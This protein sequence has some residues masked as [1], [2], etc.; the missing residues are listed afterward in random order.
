MW[1]EGFVRYLDLPQ[2]LNSLI[3]SIPQGESSPYWT[4]ISSNIGT[5]LTDDGYV[6]YSKGS[7]GKDNIYIGMKNAFYA[8]DQSKGFQ[9]FVYENYIPNVTPGQNSN[10]PVGLNMI[11]ANMNTM[12]ISLG[13]SDSSKYGVFYYLS[14]TR[15]RIIL[16]I[17]FP[18]SIHDRFVD[19]TNNG[20]ALIN[21][22]YMG[23]I[24]RYSDEANST[25]VTLATTH[26]VNANIY[27][28]RLLRGADGTPYQQYS[29]SYRYYTYATDYKSWGGDL[30]VV[31]N[32]LYLENEGYRG[33]LDG[34][35]FAC[36][37]ISYAYSMGTPI[38]SN[39][40]VNGKDYLLIT[41]SNS[42]QGQQD[43]F[44]AGGQYVMLIEK[45]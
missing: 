12:N 3:T 28:I 41:R 21:T 2:T 6:W 42:E 36:S 34:M 32:A 45:K 24:K 25:G 37:F 10:Q 44:S 39:V 4:M 13:G 18:V 26:D 22:T 19:T 20:Y 15:D 31:P 11:N 9:V 16:T 33:E 40:Q 8:S 43:N 30:L 1:F 35:L 17:R 23:L 5:K 27:L 7:S 14:V 38:F 29:P